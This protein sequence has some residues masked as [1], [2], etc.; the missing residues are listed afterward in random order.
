MVAFALCFNTVVPLALY[1]NE[2]WSQ[3]KAI[4]SVCVCVCVSLCV[5]A[6]A[7][8]CMCVHVCV[9]S[10]MKVIIGVCVCVHA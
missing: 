1:F 2:K 10:Q 8:A 6:R 5:C 9:W 4:V 7:Y 3:M